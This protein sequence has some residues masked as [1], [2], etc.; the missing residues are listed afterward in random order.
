M[1]FFFLASFTQV[2][3]CVLFNRVTAYVLLS[4]YLSFSIALYPHTK[5]YV[6]YI[7]FAGYFAYLFW[8][9]NN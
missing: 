2:C 3:V 6:L 8:V 9:Y 5:I 7:Y 4:L 1:Y